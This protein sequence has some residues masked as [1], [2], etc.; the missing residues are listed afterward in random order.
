MTEITPGQ[1]TRRVD[2][3]RMK[4]RIRRLTV[5][6][7]TGQPGKTSLLMVNTAEGKA[8]TS[9]PPDQPRAS[10]R[11]ND[12]QCLKTVQAGLLAGSSTQTLNIISPLNVKPLVVSTVHTAAGHSQKKEI[13]PGSAGCHYTNYALKSVKSVSCITQLSCAQPVTNVKH[14]VSNLPVGARLVGKLGWTWVPVRK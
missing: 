12:N 3:T 8:S 4:D 5:K 11:T 6:S 2:I 7:P 9:T 1:S 10:S 13:S 14:V